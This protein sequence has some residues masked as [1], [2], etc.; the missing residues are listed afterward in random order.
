[1]LLPPAFLFRFD[2]V[3]DDI[4]LRFEYFDKPR[5]SRSTL[6]FLVAVVTLDEQA[7]ASGD[8][9]A[10]FAMSQRMC[11][12]SSRCFDTSSSSRLS[13]DTDRDFLRQFV[14]AKQSDVSL[15]PDHSWCISLPS[16]GKYD[17]H[18]HLGRLKSAFHRSQGK[19]GHQNR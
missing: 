5:V 15:D 3:I 16:F 11:V 7:E 2:V 17:L 9:L 6:V 4:A 1:M 18:P 10:N 8:A 19:C 14:S 12:K 13:G